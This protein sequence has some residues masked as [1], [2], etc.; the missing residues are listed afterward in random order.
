MLI[1]RILEEAQ[2]EPQLEHLRRIGGPDE[3]LGGE[4]GD[5]VRIGPRANVEASVARV[6]TSP[7]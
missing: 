4:A 1:D 6:R 2:D 5:L 7:G 3:G